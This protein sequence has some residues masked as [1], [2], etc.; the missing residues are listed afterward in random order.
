MR[1]ESTQTG[2]LVVC[3][4]LDLLS[5]KD[6]AKDSSILA[7]HDVSAG[8]QRTRVFYIFTNISF[9]QK[10]LMVTSINVHSTGNLTD[11]EEKYNLD[12]APS[13]QYYKADR[14]IA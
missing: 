7:I 14:F 10:K 5:A 1:N 9:L 3:Y 2:R 13:R 12:K 8:P 4:F 6:S 11:L